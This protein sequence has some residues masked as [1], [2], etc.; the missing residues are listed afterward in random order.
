M[1]TDGFDFVEYAAPAPKA[2]GALFES[3]D[4]DQI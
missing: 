2:L 3:V 4:L 1:G